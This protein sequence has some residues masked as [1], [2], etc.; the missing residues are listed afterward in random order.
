MRYLRTVPAL[1]LSL[2]LLSLLI[3]GVW[4]WLDQGIPSWD[5]A[6]H[7]IG[8][9]NY[10]WAL[11]QIQPTSD[12]WQGFWTLSSKYPPLL[13]VS[14]APLLALL[15]RS[16]DAAVLVNGLYS[17]ILLLAVYGLGQRL[18]SPKVGLWAAGLALVMPQ[19]YQ[20][21]TEYYM[22]YAL[23]ALVALTLWALTQWAVRR[24]RAQ[25]GWAIAFG[26]CLGLAFLAKQTALLF[27][28]VPVGWL[29]AARLWRRQWGQVGQLAAAG[30]VALLL[31]LPWSTT[32][33]FFQVSAAFSANTRSA[34]I[35]GDPSVA[36][37]AGWLFYWQRLPQMVSWPLLALPLAG[38]ILAVGRGKVKA[39]EQ[40]A[41][42]WLGLFLGGSYLIW[43]AIANKDV[44]YVMPWL[45]VLAIVLAYGL[46]HLPRGLRWGTAALGL[47]LMLANLFGGLLGGNWQLASLLS[48]GAAHS[49][50]LGAPYPHAE[51]IAEMVAQQPYQVM[52]LGVLPSTPQV[53]QHSLTYFGNREDFRVYA[54]R[55]GKSQEHL[56]QDRSAFNW[57]LSV[58]RPQLSY[59]SQ[60]ARRR[61]VQM[62]QG[63]KPEFRR[64]RRWT[65]PDGS[66]LDLWRRRQMPVQVQP[67]D[68]PVSTVELAALQ[69][70]TQAIAGMPTPVT[71]RWRGPWRDLHDGVVLLSWQQGDADAWLHDHSIGLGQLHPQPIQSNQ[72]VLAATDIDPEQT[73]EVVEQIAMLPP[74]G[75]QGAYRLSATYLNRV[76]GETYALPLPE[77]RLR[78]TSAAL[79][80]EPLLSDL[81]AVSQLRLLA[82]ALPQG[83]DALGPVFDQVGRLSLYDPTQRYL[84]DAEVSLTH[85]LAQF[86]DA[87]SL[88]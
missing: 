32:N 72:T 79:E 80:Q 52:T 24:R 17:L 12:W 75:S 16:L 41:L 27:F 48:P 18:F 36:T 23:T 40:R 60:K 1:L 22:D 70:P 38:L 3:D 49:P 10:W 31:L 5:P 51:I 11:G 47:G 35:E 78:V 7:H 81:D 15:G 88:R 65:L 55:A 4:L 50:Y 63:L 14:T 76:T 86:P 64:Q 33:W 71:Y 83:P 73:F 77:Q 67:I 84:A 66:R 59:H 6:D 61:Q 19:L 13:Y 25:W 8:A 20:T 69:L 54:R 43:T 37:V 42:G 44:R 68:T 29:V 56:A 74:A 2:W 45:P 85:R 28:A 62:A 34:A 21:R 82:Q 46:W 26:A 87:L 57:F 9:L 39:Q 53:N 58:T 30:G